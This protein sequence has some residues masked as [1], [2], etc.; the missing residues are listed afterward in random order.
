MGISEGVVFQT[1]GTA[2]EKAL[3]EKCAL[4]LSESSQSERRVVSGEEVTSDEGQITHLI[5]FY[6][7]CNEEPS[8]GVERRRVVTYA[9]E[10]PP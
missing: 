5:G 2:S 3:R 9:P 6:S 10:G 4:I 1:E 7:E 8:Q